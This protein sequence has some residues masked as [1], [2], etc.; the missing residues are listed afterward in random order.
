MS[1][2]RDDLSFKLET[3]RFRDLTNDYGAPLILVVLLPFFIYFFMS[4]CV[5]SLSSRIK[6]K[7]H[8][9]FNSIIK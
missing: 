4:S 2:V 9:F 6:T 7:S 1:F 8:D 5:Y 3:C